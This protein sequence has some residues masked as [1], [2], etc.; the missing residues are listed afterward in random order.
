MVPTAVTDLTILD[1]YRLYIDYTIRS[2]KYTHTVRSD[3]VPCD[4]L[5]EVF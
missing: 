3:A 1:V 2:Y 5:G 4:T